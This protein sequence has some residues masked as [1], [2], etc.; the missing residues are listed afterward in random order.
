MNKTKWQQLMES[1]KGC[2]EF[3]P[4]QSFVLHVFWVV[5][6]PAAAK[7]MIT[8]G[9]TPCG[10]ATLRDTPTTICY[11][12]RIAKDQ[13][14]ALKLKEEI[15]TISQH[16]HYQNAFKSIKFGIPRAAVES[17]LKFGEINVV[18]LSWQPDEPISEHEKELDYDPIVLET[19]EV[20][21]DNRSFYEHSASHDWMKYSAEILK[22]NRSLKPK[23]YCIGNPDKNIWDKV[24]EPTLK[25]IKFDESNNHQIK[26]INPEIVFQKKSYP[27]G[28]KV[29]F[30]ELDLVVQKEKMGQCRSLL[31][32][33]E[34]ELIA[35]FMIIFPTNIDNGE[36]VDLLKIRCMIAAINSKDLKSISLKKLSPE[37]EKFDGRIF[38]FERKEIQNKTKNDDIKLKNEEAALNFIQRSEI[39]NLNLTII[40]A[41]KARNEQK[42]AG[43][44]FHPLFEKLVPNASI[45]YQ[46]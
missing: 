37:C 1:P 2:L 27:E 18:P 40:D 5:R 44:A 8:K 35:I 36:N 22:A 21:L 19:T 29:F 25:A 34:E 45:N 3:N 42:L 11:F 43:Y 7:E 30:F 38:V 23:T 16:P 33:I 41:E 10:K 20:Y 28:D 15:K 12:F 32:K 14:L 4:H 24:I 46:I 6:S 31:S 13:S 39:S 9:F 17:K 26:E